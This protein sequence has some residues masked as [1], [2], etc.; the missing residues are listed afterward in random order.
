[1]KNLNYIQEGIE[2]HFT[3]FGTLVLMLA[4][5]GTILDDLIG[6]FGFS[7]ISVIGV[8]LWIGGLAGIGF[9]YERE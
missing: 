6:E 4:I 5:E 2:S 3:Y 7:V 1:M 9:V 8:G